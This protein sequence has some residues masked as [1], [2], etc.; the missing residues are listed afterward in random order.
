MNYH[1]VDIGDL[2]NVVYDEAGMIDVNF[3]DVSNLS[4]LPHAEGYIGRRSL[5]MHLSEGGGDRIACCT[6]PEPTKT[7]EMIEDTCEDVAHA[8]CDFVG[9]AYGKIA[10]TERN[11]GGSTNVRFSGELDCPGCGNQAMGFH[12]HGAAPFDAD[13]NLSCAAAGGHFNYGDQI[14]GL[15]TDEM[16]NVDGA[17]YGAL[18]NVFLAVDNR[19]TVDVTSD[20][21]SFEG[22]NNG[23][24]DL[25]MVLHADIDKGIDFVSTNQICP[26]F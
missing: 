16:T 24:L 8:E 20:R 9:T 11:C 18:G 14:H 6:I 15:P 1:G 21:I 5:V 23:I 10:I 25:G 4:L 2:G 13:G 22:E 7:E 3:S 12:V 26:F 19:I 17:H